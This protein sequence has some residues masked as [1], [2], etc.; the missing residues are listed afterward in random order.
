MRAPLLSRSHRRRSQRGFSPKDIERLQ[1]WLDFS[2]RLTLFTDSA[3]TTPVTSDGDVIG[4]VADKSG[5]GNDATQATTAN[6]PLYKT[7]IQNGLSIARFDGTNDLL[8]LVNLGINGSQNRSVFIIVSFNASDQ[9]Y[10]I[11]LGSNVINKA[12]K[13]RTTSGDVFRIEIKTGFY[14]SSLVTNPALNLYAAILDGTTLGDITLRK[15]GTS[16]SASGA[17]VVNTLEDGTNQIGASGLSAFFLDGDISEIIVYDSALNSKQ[18]S[19]IE[20]FLNNKWAVY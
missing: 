14:D 11:A 5:N 1:L 19:Q 13:L 15:N 9:D 2:D 8:D 18:I 12:F 16:E 6:K 4:A 17:E 7:G 20:N 3:K 10:C